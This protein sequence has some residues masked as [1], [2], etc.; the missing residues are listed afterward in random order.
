M[1]NYIYRGEP[2]QRVFGALP[3]GDYNYVVSECSE[4]YQKDNGNWVLAVRLAIQPSGTTVFSNPWTGTDKNGQ[5]RDGIAEF[6]V[7]CNRAPKLGTEPDWAKI[8]GARG[9]C[10]LKVEIAQMGQL[11]GKEVNKVGW[12]H[13]PKQVGPNAEQAPRQSY[14]QEEYNQAGAEAVKKAGGPVRPDLEPEP[15]DIP[16]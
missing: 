15:D 10:R 13:A 16:F 1:S 9:R 14:S 5:E 8:V 6:L 4:P 11:A 2:E 12:F 7:S 3:E